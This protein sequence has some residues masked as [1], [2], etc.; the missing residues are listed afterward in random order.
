M[1]KILSRR[2]VV[3]ASV[4]CYPLCGAVAAVTPAQTKQAE[5]LLSGGKPAEA[6]QLLAGRVELSDGPQTWFL[7]GKAAEQSGDLPT[8]RTAYQMVIAKNPKAERVKLDLARVMQR[9]GDTENASR[10]F[11]EVRATNPPAQVVANIDRY[12]AMMN[13]R[14]QVGSAWRARATVGTGYDSNPG[15]QTS[16]R[17]VTMF[18]LPFTL[19]DTARK[20]GAAFAFVKGEFDHIYRFSRDYAW[21]TSV[22]FSARK[23]F[24]LSDFDNFSG[25]FSTG[26]VW[27]P[28]DRTTVLLPL[29]ASVNRVETSSKSFDDRWHSWE[30]GA[31]PQIRYAALDWLNLNFA[32]TVGRR[33]YIKDGDKDAI[34]AS[35]SPGVDVK[36]PNAGTI[37]LGAALGRELAR[38]APNSNASFGVNAGW[39]YNFASNFVASFYGN[40]TQSYYDAPEVIYGN[41]R[42]R[43]DRTTVGAELIYA[44]ETIGS[45]ILLSY[46]HTWNDSNLPIYSYDRDTVSV[47][48]RKGL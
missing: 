16:A 32:T 14:D 8:A 23:H 42:R 29:Y 15:T 28:G 13:N 36:I 40:Y 10:L 48:V 2:M 6:R 5:A 33:F 45:D 12:L 26:P 19:S 35:V 38:T 3:L 18:G 17:D 27:Q 21:A 22:S 34:V 37:S 7:Y 24:G 20:R 30:M 46:A 11:H 4:L 47:A 1:T 39:Q 41:D 31:A 9:Q 25:N 43:D 44:W